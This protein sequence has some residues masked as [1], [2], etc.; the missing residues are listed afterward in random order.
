MRGVQARSFNN[1]YRLQLRLRS[2]GGASFTPRYNRDA[3]G[4]LSSSPHAVL[5]S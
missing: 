5:D 2:H 3:R 4:G 1:I